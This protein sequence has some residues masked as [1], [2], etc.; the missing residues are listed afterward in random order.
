MLKE[1]SLTF[2][3]K[4]FT[5]FLGFLVVIVT[6][7]ILGPEGRGIYAFLENMINLAVLFGCFGV[8]TA[9]VYFLGR[10]KYSFN[11]LFW[12]SVIIGIIGGS[13]AIGGVKI[14]M[15]ISSNP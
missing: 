7:R 15:I 4:V 14:L 1:S 5:A 11:V 12:N 3:T 9:N 8:G 13:I 6:A 2:F 10:K